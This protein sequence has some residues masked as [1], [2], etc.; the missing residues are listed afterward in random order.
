MMNIHMKEMARHAQHYVEYLKE[1]IELFF[2]NGL[3][4]INVKIYLDCEGWSGDVMAFSVP[5]QE[6]DNLI[7]TVEGLP[8]RLQMI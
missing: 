7:S 3:G 5:A 8:M 2:R 4:G 1:Q 6:K